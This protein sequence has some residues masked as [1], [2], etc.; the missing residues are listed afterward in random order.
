MPKE[1]KTMPSK[2]NVKKVGSKSV[3]NHNP[4]F[5]FAFEKKNY[6]WM[7]VGI[8]LLFIGYLLLIGGGSD[9]PDVF[10]YDLFS[11][12]R[13]VLAPIFMIGGIGVE[14]YAIL[15]KAKGKKEDEVKEQ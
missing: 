12:R 13:L 15:L 14:I 7:F 11:A 9:N 6:I 4:K 1:N 3:Q 8:A 10:N 5:D 2:A